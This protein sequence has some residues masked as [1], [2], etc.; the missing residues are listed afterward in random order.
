MATIQQCHITSHRMTDSGSVPPRYDLVWAVRVDSQVSPQELLRLARNVT[1][2]A[3]ITPLP[4]KGDEYFYTAP[5]NT[6][7]RDKGA[8][9]LD[10]D[11]DDTLDG[12]VYDVRVAY[13][14]PRLGEDEEP[15][16]VIQPPLQRPPYYWIEYYTETEE[17]YTARLPRGF[18][19]E[20]TRKSFIGQGTVQRNIG[21]EGPI[22]TA[23]GEETDIATD[24][25]IH[26]VLCCQR[27]VVGPQVAARINAKYSSTINR[28]P[29][30]I[31]RQFGEL[32]NITERRTVRQTE[33]LFH[34]ARF[35]RAETGQFPLWWDGDVYYRMQVRVRVAP[36]EFY[37]RIPNSGTWKYLPSPD[38]KIELV[39]TDDGPLRKGHLNSDGTLPTSANQ[40]SKP[41]IIPY[42]IS[43]DISYQS[44]VGFNAILPA[45]LQV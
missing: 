30:R 14:T 23:A 22:T 43:E 42:Q 16:R 44:D 21:E 24:E 10:F 1:A 25:R 2:S 19:T 20:D 28:R 37:K 26:T 31:P 34:K 6:K 33:V 11:V 29:W 5:D 41:L 39:R 32:E 15:E 38:N 45:S 35:L 7:S 17:V 12:K 36:V 8:I 4:F 27:N 40:L 13:R 9:A 3:T 18:R